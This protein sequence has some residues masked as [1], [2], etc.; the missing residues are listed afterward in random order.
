[1]SEIIFRAALSA[2][3]AAATGSSQ[4]SVLL[5]VPVFWDT[6]SHAPSADQ[7]YGDQ[8][9]SSSIV[10]SGSSLWVWLDQIISCCGV[11]TMDLSRMYTSCWPSGDHNP[12]A[13][14]CLSAIIGASRPSTSDF[15]HTS[16]APA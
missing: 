13:R 16:Q 5:I 14:L 4:T 8:R 11:D 3:G 7:S 10:V 6:S 1:G 9:V 2:C 12:A 15:S